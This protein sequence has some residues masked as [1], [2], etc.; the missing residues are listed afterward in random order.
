VIALGIFL[1]TALVAGKLAVRVR[2]A[3]RESARWSEA[4]SALL[5]VATQAAQSN[6][7]APVVDV[8]REPG[9]LGG[10]DL[11]VVNRYEQDGTMTPVAASSK[12]AGELDIGARSERVGASIAR[13]V[14]TGAPAR[15][16]RC[17]DSTGPIANEPRKP[18]IRSA[19]GCPIMVAGRLWGVF[20]ALPKSGT[21]IP[22]GTESEIARFTD[23]VAAAILTS[24]ESRAELSASRAR[25]VAA[26]D[27]VRR[28]L[29]RDLHDGVQQRLVSVGLKLRLACD[30]V[31]VELSTVHANLC[32]LTEELNEAQEELR[33]LARGLH[34]SILSTAG[35]VPA[36]RT[37]ARRSAVPVTLH[38]DTEARYPAPVELTAFYVVSE[39]LTNTIKHANASW[40]DVVVEGRDTALVVSIRD[41]GG[42]GADPRSGSGLIGLRDR[43]EAIGG[44]MQITSPVAGGTTIHISLPI[45]KID[46]AASDWSPHLRS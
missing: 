29:G 46:G 35:L 42:G 5:R 36:L 23:V 30:E 39:A 8:C 15:I 6:P 34:P 10:A 26:A 33:E 7:P 45:D 44:S 43:V 40:V 11:A 19:I 13:E 9:L 31:P 2:Q 16:C 25:V 12:A 21:A 37:L 3:A 14:R 1:I 18:G 38:V 41:D 20:V 24:A 22:P 28:R 32:Q 27:E 17:A 4:Q